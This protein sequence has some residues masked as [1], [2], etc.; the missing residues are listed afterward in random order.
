[1]RSASP[2]RPPSSTPP[3]TN[4][5]LVSR[6]ASALSMPMTSTTSPRPWRIRACSPAG[7]AA[8]DELADEGAEQDRADVDERS[9]HRGVAR[10]GRAWDEGQASHGGARENG[11]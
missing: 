10:R 4:S 6:Q 3:S 5:R 7:Q 8:A 11:R 2:A 1:M 9:G